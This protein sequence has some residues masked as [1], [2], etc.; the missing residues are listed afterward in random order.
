MVS[1]SPNISRD[2][3]DWGQPYIYQF[4]FLQNSIFFLGVHMLDYICIF[5]LKLNNLKYQIEENQLIYQSF[6]MMMIDLRLI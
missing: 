3:R 2:S 5:A 6:L 1:V 4:V